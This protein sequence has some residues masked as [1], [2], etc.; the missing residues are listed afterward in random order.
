MCCG[1]RTGLYTNL[2]SFPASV[3]YEIVL[4]HFG[5]LVALHASVVEVV[6]GSAVDWIVES[7]VDGAVDGSFSLLGLLL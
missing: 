3:M 2:V 5:T 1:Y 7:T 4:V 6:V